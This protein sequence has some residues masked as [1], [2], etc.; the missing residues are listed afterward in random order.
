MIADDRHEMNCL[1]VSEVTCL[2]KTLLEGEPSLRGVMIKGE[3]SN[4][5]HHSSGHMYFTLK[6]ERS[7]LR[8][9]MFRNRS[10]QVKFR[11][12]DGLT[13]IV[14]GFIGVYEAA[15]D[16]QLYVEEM[17]PAGQGALYLAFE[18]LKQRMEAEGLFAQERK[19][20]LPFLPRT[21]GVVTSPTGAAV[22]D[23]ISVL[24]R[25]NPTVSIILAPAI[26]QGEAGPASVVSAIEL[27]NRYGLVD[28]LIVGRGGGSLEELWTFNDEQVARAIAASRVPVVS[29]VGHETDFTIADFVADRRAPT[30]SAAAEIVVPERATLVSQVNMAQDRMANAL[31]RNI[32]VRR[33][34]VRLL[35]ASPALTRPADRI[36][37]RRQQVDEVLRRAEAEFAQRLATHRAK[38]ESL[39]GIL[40]TLSPLATLSRGYSICQLAQ[41]N[42]VVTR[43]GQVSRGTPLLIRVSDGT[44]R[45]REDSRGIDQQE[46]LPI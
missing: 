34:H 32:Q 9:V 24:H 15:G 31:R 4:F 16:Y 21:V 27:L 42:E 30:P 25:R 12:E 17:H 14:R 35:S 1:T 43:T 20:P 33:E 37:Q 44:I 28:V 22:R 7:R 29:A 5:K 41:T 46:L 45:C 40:D 18:Q 10:S 8:S 19:R 38:L 11:P 23:I 26:V 36:D 13:V 39:A 3:I 2:V 6:D